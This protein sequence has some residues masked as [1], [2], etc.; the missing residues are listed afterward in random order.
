MT[1]ARS[2]APRA[3]LD[4]AERTLADLQQQTN[5]L[6]LEAAEGKPGADKLLAVHRGKLEL[7]QR[8]VAELRGAVAL[9]ERLDREADAHA[10]AS[11][12]AE[13]LSAF[14]E[15]MADR[16]E[17]MVTMIEAA[18]TMAKAFGQFI[19]ASE[20]ARALVPDGTALPDIHVGQHGLCG[21]SFGPLDRLIA[22]EMW[23]LAPSRGEGTNAHIALPF[24]A[25][26]TEQQ[27]FRPDAIPAALPEF[28]AAEAANIAAV[29]QQVEQINAA[30]LAATQ[31][32]A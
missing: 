32:A 6:A 17:A 16:G 23:R 19:L 29:E 12:R 5:V 15:A 7:A 18:G 21:R 26:V 24:A 13:Q 4:Q 9:A 2:S 11:S 20:R 30:E 31:E 8:I 25:P 27:R 3:K 10:A 22:A 1:T 28:Q 14:K